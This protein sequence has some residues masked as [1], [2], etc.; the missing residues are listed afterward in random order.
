M[1]AYQTV[2]AQHVAPLHVTPKFL[3]YLTFSIPMLI[4][5][6]LYGYT[7]QLPLFLDDGPQF[8]MVEVFTGFD[9]WLGSPAYFYYRPAVF[10]IWKLSSVLAGFF[11]AAGLHWLNLMFFGMTGVV[12]SAITYR[13]MPKN[14]L[15]T[16][17]GVGVGFI[18]FPFNYQTVILVGAM[19][20]TSM[21]FC[22]ALTIWTALLWWDKPRLRWLIIAIMSAFW[23]IFSHENGVLIAPLTALAIWTAHGHRAVLSRRIITLIAPI[24]IITAIYLVL[25]VTV[26]RA[27]SL[28]GLRPIGN[29][30]ESFGIMMQSSVYPLSA[31]LRPLVTDTPSAWLTIIMGVGTLGIGLLLIAI[32]MPSLK[33]I[34]L[35]GVMWYVMALMPTV[36]LLDTAYVDGSPRI[37]IYASMGL[38]VFYGAVFSA[39]WLT[40][41]PTPSPQGGEGAKNLILRFF[42]RPFVILTCALMLIVSIPFIHT[43]RDHLMILNRYMRDLNTLIQHQPQNPQTTPILLVNAPDYIT[44]KPQNRTFLRGSEGVAMMFYLVDYDRQIWVN[45]GI[46]PMVR[47]AKIDEI[48]RG[49]GYDVYLHDPATSWDEARALALTSATIY[50][51]QFNGA[52]FYPVYVGAP[53]LAGDDAPDVIFGEDIILY[54]AQAVFMPKK[55]A[56]LVKLRWGVMMDTPQPLKPFVHIVCDGALVAQLDGHVWG[57]IYPFEAWQAGEIQ[58]EYRHIPM[59]TPFDDARCDVVVGVYH[60]MTGDRLT[61]LNAITRE[62]YPNDLAPILTIGETNEPFP[63]D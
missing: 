61:A 12:L 51:T 43:R 53:N 15:I 54:D 8:R 30:I 35:F 47:T 1:N 62:T 29:M 13:L 60:Q 58:T 32:F 18:I 11:D 56:M 2:R 50:M 46:L 4:A 39:I 19:F 52:E 48:N 3:K 25:Y 26:P 28:G 22:T 34:G 7:V 20:H 55:S 27:E 42:T 6:L 59:P 33:R 57:D 10:S 40:P 5:M 45:T 38:H 49:Q 21:I 16:A 44:P 63:F 17:L 24:G 37:L 14:R 23:G 36:M 41:P 9:Q 31:L